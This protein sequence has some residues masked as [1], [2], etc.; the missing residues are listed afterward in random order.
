MVLFFLEEFG[1]YALW[2][3]S[4]EKITNYGSVFKRNLEVIFQEDI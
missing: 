3:C 4:V 1:T 2:Y